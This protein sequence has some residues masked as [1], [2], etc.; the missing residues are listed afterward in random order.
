MGSSKVAVGSSKV[1]GS[2]EVAVGSSKVAVGSGKVFGSSKV[3]AGSSNVFVVARQR[4]QMEAVN[5]H[6]V[7]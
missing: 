7:Q 3:A 6:V 5:T 4:T 1:F 2:S